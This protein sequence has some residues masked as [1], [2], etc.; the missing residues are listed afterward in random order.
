MKILS[1]LLN[2]WLG[3]FKT[4]R[5]LIKFLG[6]LLKYLIENNKVYSLIILFKGKLDGSLKTQK[7]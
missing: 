1:Q 6:L 7:L 5:G 3:N 2:F 4:Q